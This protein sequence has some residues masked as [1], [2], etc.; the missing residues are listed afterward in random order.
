M[1]YIRAESLVNPYPGWARETNYVIQ[2]H[3]QWQPEDPYANP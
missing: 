2:S 1:I 3:S